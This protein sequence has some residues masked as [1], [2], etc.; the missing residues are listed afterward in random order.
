MDLLD[1]EWRDSYENIVRNLEEQVADAD[2]TYAASSWTGIRT[3]RE[4][5]AIVRGLAPVA[6]GEIDALADLI[7]SKRFNDPVTADAVQCLRDLHQQLGDLIDAIDR[8]NM[9]RAAVEAIEANRERLTDYVKQGA[10]LT[11]VA[12]AMTFGIMHLLAWLSGVPIDSTIVSTVYGSVVG[13]DASKAFT[14][15]SSLAGK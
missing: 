13:A 3:M 6:L 12:P 8:G 10:K 15:K 9:T 7:E 4:Q 1:D 2:N 14:K 5:V 11:M